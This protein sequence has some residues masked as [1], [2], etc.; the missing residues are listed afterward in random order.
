MAADAANGAMGANLLEG[1]ATFRV[2]DPTSTRVTVRGTFN[3][4][5]DHPLD[6][7]AAGFWSAF[8]PG[9]KSGDQYK[10]FVVG[11]GTTGCKRDPFARALTRTPAFPQ[12]D[13]IVTQPYSFPW[14][15]SGYR[16]PPFHELVLYQL[17]VGAFF[18]TDEK[19]NDVRQSRPGRFLDVLL[20]IDHLVA[21]GVNAV[22]IMPVQEF[23]TMRSLGYNGLDYFSPEMDYTIDP[24]APEFA[25]YFDRA[26]ELLTRHGLAHFAPGDL[27]CPT[28]QLMALIDLLHLHGI[29]V[30]LDVVYNHAGGG[31]D[32]DSIFFHDRQAYGDNN[33]S[34][35]FTDQGWAGGLVFAYWK[36]EVRQFLIDNAG[37]F[38]DEYHV[39]GF[40]FDEVTVIDS[41]GGWGFLQDLTST[42][43]YRKP[44]AILIAEYWADQ[45]SVLRSRESLGA[46]FDAVVASGLREAIRKTLGEVTCGRDASVN[47][48]RVAV[49]LV[50]SFDHAWRSVQHLENQDIVRVDNRTD[51]APR[52]PAA[53]DSTNARSWYATSRSRVVNGLL[54]TAP[55]I[56]MLF[57]GQEILEDK[58]WSDS[59]EYFANSLIWWDGLRVDRAMQ[60]HLKFVQDV[61][62]VRRSYRALTGDSIRVFHVHNGNRV[63]AFHR[64]LEGFGGDVVVV[65]SFHEET[66]HAYSLGLP[67]PGTWREVFNSDAYENFP[68]PMA[69]GNQGRIDANG[70]PL[71]GFGCSA[72]IVIPANSILVFAAS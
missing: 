34:L 15:D 56:P 37:F 55:G 50:P 39:D 14:H 9:V 1:G 65:A 29:A 16:P 72:T 58:Y 44:Q 3:S 70:P 19:G 22:Q 17:H 62:R 59:P 12:S 47:L 7:S 31:F 63:I 53:S 5:A 52:V 54:L 69:S 10:Y 67:L 33:R 48:D 43:R 20:Q 8:V 6:R 21:L 45:S 24:A 68:N 11:Q 36:S 23:A 18:A 64:W 2:W 25:R 4:W 30:V 66:W 57:M 60:D 41:H 26:N 35:Y 27:D 28:K 38:Y 49:A 51:R 13:C 42:L 46:G 40:R 61:L 32:D 71:H